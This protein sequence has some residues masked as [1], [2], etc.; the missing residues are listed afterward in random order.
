MRVKQGLAAVVAALAVVVGFVVPTRAQQP[1]AT[2]ATVIISPVERTLKD[3]AWLIDALNVPGGFGGLIP[4]MGDNYTTG[5]D[6][7]RP[8]GVVVTLQDGTPNPV[9]CLPN[10]DHK[11]F[12]AK[13]SEASLQVDDLGNG[14]YEVAVGPQLIMAKV[15]EKWIFVGQTEDAVSNPPADPATLFGDYHTRYN[16]TVKIDLQ[17]LPADLKQSAIDNLRAGFEGAM[18]QAEEDD[19]FA[20]EMGELQMAQIEE[21]INSTQQVVLGWLIDSGRQQIH[22]DGAVQY[23]AGSKLAKQMDAQAKLKSDLSGLSSAASSASFRVTSLTTDE[24]DKK[25]AKQSIRN[26]IKQI[27]KQIANTGNVPEE[28]QTT[29]FEFINGLAGVF[30][31]TIDE[32]VI[33]GA[34]NLSVEGDELN[35]VMGARIA[36]GPTLEAKLKD[37]VKE[38]PSTDDVVVQF[39]TGTHA[40]FNLH[41]VNIRIPSNEAEARAVFG[42]TVKVTIAASPKL[43]LF[44]VSKQG[45]E[46]IKKAIDGL[47][48]KKNADV[49]APVE[50]VIRLAALLR[51][52]QSIKP[53]PALENV[54]NIM[55]QYSG[56]DKISFKSTILP[57]GMVTRVT[58]DEGVLRS[59][60]AAAQAGQ[61][62]GGF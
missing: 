6:K 12:F 41:R 17:Q 16:V 52:A 24:A 31:K 53:N 28:I 1:A 38:L 5:L 3:T 27:E 39:D 26:S 33:D 18:Q 56:K 25:V 42:E 30:D 19:E 37:L 21:L 23:S 29:I 20:K 57:R 50:G 14:L 9:V 51:Y 46:S 43:V 61:G 11:E 55:S 59:I 60:G 36:D 62:G 8:L 40:G 13:L 47:N 45:E 49:D 58:I 10:K 34:F 22:L 15:T 4:I 44:G 48:T 54:I 32:G 7:S 35:A 2:I